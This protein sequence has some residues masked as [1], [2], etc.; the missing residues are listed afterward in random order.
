MKILNFVFIATAATVC[1][2]G[3]GGIVLGLAFALTGWAP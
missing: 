2:V 3:L 1:M